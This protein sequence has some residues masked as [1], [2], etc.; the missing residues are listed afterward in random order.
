MEKVD[1]EHDERDATIADLRA[2]LKK[3]QEAH[4]ATKATKE[5]S[6]EQ[7]RSQLTAEREAHR[8]TRIELRDQVDYTQRLEVWG[9]QQAKRA[10]RNAGLA[11][12][13]GLGTVLGAVGT[14]SGRR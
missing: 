4:A 2:A 6:E 11:V 1:K 5:R 13:G 3:E 14:F 9:A 10:D 12:L 7:L 8:L